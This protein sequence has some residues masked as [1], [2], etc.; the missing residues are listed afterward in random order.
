MIQT[1]CSSS[2]MIIFMIKEHLMAEYISYL[3]IMQ[4]WERV[5]PGRILNVQYEVSCCKDERS[6]IFL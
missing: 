4:H 1:K 5:L 2:L 6:E 3:E